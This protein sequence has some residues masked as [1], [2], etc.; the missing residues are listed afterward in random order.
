MEV[1]T[2]H[3]LKPFL[4]LIIFRNPALPIT[5]AS[6]NKI[7]PSKLEIIFIFVHKC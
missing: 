1:I 6:E 4:C 3:L 2:T 5:V 7:L